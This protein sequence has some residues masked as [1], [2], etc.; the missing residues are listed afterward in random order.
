MESSFKINISSEKPDEPPPFDITNLSPMTN[1]ALNLSGLSTSVAGTPNRRISWSNPVPGGDKISLNLD[2][3]S[4][5]DSP[6]FHNVLPC[7]SKS[8]VATLQKYTHNLAWPS[9]LDDEDK[10][11]ATPKCK[12][13][14]QPISTEKDEFECFSQDSGYLSSASKSLFAGCSPASSYFTKVRSS[15]FDD[16]SMD[17]IFHLDGGKDSQELL[18]V[19]ESMSNLLT[20]PLSDREKPKRPANGTRRGKL[21][22][23]RC[24]SM[25]I[26]SDSESP[27][28]TSSGSLHSISSSDDKNTEVDLSKKCTFKRPEPPSDYFSCQNKRRKSSPSLKLPSPICE[29]RIQRSYSETAATITQVLMKTDSQPEL[30]GDG[31]RSC[32]LPLVRGRHQD[33]KSITCA[34]L[35]RLLN[36]DYKNEVDNFKLIDCRYPY[37]YDGGHIKGAENLYTKEDIMDFL[38]EDGESNKKSIIIFHCEFSSERAPSLCRFLRNK[39]RELNQGNY[40]HLNHPEVYILE[41]GYKAFYENHKELCEPQGYKPMKHKDHGFELRHFRAKS[42]SWGSDTRSRVPLKSC[43]QPSAI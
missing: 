4:S 31:S 11:N 8:R 1:L 39:D 20:K 18:A 15:V 42:K 38:N 26:D 30:I 28:P 12:S 6:T 2:D 7:S 36:G 27:I 37:E 33:L 24:L 3:I 22:I 35:V 10:E 43:S 29:Y 19:P 25:D 5:T 21:P 17:N 14:S 16:D 40:P 23:R 32:A 41:G 34:T 13:L 9:D